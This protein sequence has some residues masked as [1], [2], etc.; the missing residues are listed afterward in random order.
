MK[1]DKENKD[2]LYGL[3]W[4]KFQEIKSRTDIVHGRDLHNKFLNE[5]GIKRV[6]KAK[7]LR[8]RVSMNKS[9]WIWMNVHTQTLARD[10]NSII[11]LDPWW[12]NSENY[13]KLRSRGYVD[14][15]SIPKSVAEKFLV[16]GVP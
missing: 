9:A 4:R 1:W 12:G 13:P 2:K 6:Q 5:F 14:G 16:L 10:K 7:R 8:D 11:I 3:I 15:L